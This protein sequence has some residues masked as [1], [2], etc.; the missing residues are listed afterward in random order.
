M[1]TTR[2]HGGCLSCGCTVLPEHRCIVWSLHWVSSFLCIHLQ[3]R[4]LNSEDS[5]VAMCHAWALHCVTKH[6]T[7]SAHLWELNGWHHHEGSE[8]LDWGRDEGLETSRHTFRNVLCN[9]VQANTMSAK[10]QSLASGSLRFE[11]L[12]CVMCAF[13]FAFVQGPQRS[14]S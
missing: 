1:T 3:K 4:F 6:P 9:A 2:T 14:A 7:G 13:A 5:A 12:M 10:A 11:P 8:L